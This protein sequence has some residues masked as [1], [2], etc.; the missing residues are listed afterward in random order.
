MVERCARARLWTSF[1]SGLT[2]LAVGGYGRRHLFPYSDIDLML[3]METNRLAQSAP[4]AISGF[5]PGPLGFRLAPEPL[6]AHAG[7]MR[8]DSRSKHRAE[9]Q[10]ARSALCWRATARCTA[11]SPSVCRASCTRS[12]IHWRVIL[13]DL[14]ANVIRSIRTLTIT[15]SRTSRIRR[16][17][18]A[19]INWCAGCRGCARWK[20]QRWNRRFCF[21]RACVV[22][23]IRWPAAITTR[24]VSTRRNRPPNTLAVPGAAPWMREYFRHARE[25]YR[26]AIRE[27]EWSEAQSS[28]LFAQF[29]DWRTRLSNADFSVARERVHLRAPHALTADPELALRL[30]QFV[31][32]HGIRPST[33]TEQRIAAAMPQLEEWLA[34]ARPIWPAMKEILSLPFAA[35]A[36][37][38]M[39]ESRRLARGVPGDGADRVPGGARFLPSLHG[40]RAHPG[41]IAGV[42]GLARQPRTRREAVQR[43]AGGDGRSRV[44]LLRAAVSRCGKGRRG[45]R[46]C[47]GVRAGG[48]AGPGAHRHAATRAR[49][50]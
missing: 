42:G 29:K 4:E 6:G 11:S 30:F 32:R 31:A 48:G 44:A 8:G 24:S 28:T 38:S 2:L 1:P 10:P 27:L 36:V 19:I 7:R 34:T 3:L 26:T 45:R 35:D 22:S 18:C 47:R 16:A 25:L 15:W 20:R 41:D 37:R 33:E 50:S 43:S 9:R 21:W 46:T 17:D 40:G 5:H 12:A 23:C 13:R 49:I 39:H 14:L